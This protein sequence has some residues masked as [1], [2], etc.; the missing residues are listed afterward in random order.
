MDKTGL[1]KQ[2]FTRARNSSRICLT[3]LLRGR[4]DRR[5]AAQCSDNSI[6]IDRRTCG[7]P[8]SAAARRLSLENLVASFPLCAPSPS[9]RIRPVLY[10]RYPVCVVVMVV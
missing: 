2:S 10:Y 5:D 3:K 8:Y 1:E 7:L 9:A 4:S 6:R